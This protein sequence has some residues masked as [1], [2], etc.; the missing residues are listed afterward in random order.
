MIG[1]AD[2]VHDVAVKIDMIERT[3]ADQCTRWTAWKKPKLDNGLLKRIL[4]TG[5]AGHINNSRNH[6]NG[7]HNADQNESPRRPADRLLHGFFARCA[8]RLRWATVIV[9][10]DVVLRTS[11]RYR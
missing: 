6:Q 8:A 5:S 2:C 11:T 9:A 1:C 4:L 7:N 10:L 3:G